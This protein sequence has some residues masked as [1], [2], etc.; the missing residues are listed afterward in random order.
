[1]GA[2]LMALSDTRLNNNLNLYSTMK[3]FLLAL[4]MFV[5]VATVA[6]AQ[7]VKYRSTDFAI[8]TQRSNGSWTEWSDWQSCQVLVVVNFNNSTVQIYSQETQEFDIIEKVSD[9]HND[10][11]GGQQ[12]EVACVDKDG[13][14]C[15]MRFRKQND[16]QL[17]LYIDYRDCMYVYNI[18]Q[19]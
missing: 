15:N 19:R 5:G 9:W 4:L 7:V 10:G 16:G 11:D 14:R 6:N 2:K 1:M 17:Q 12:F 8:K 18:V 13:L 3:K